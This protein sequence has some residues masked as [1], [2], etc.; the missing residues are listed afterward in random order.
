VI[1]S[2]LSRRPPNLVPIS[3]SMLA[4][5][6]AHYSMR[7][8]S[9]CIRPMMHVSCYDAQVAMVSSTGDTRTAMLGLV[10]A[11]TIQIAQAVQTASRGAADALV[12]QTVAEVEAM[13]SCQSVF[14]SSSGSSCVD[15][16]SD[17]NV[18]SSVASEALSTAESKLSASILTG[19]DLFLSAS[20][21]ALSI[22]NTL[23]ARIQQLNA[24]ACSATAST[25]GGF[26]T[27]AAS[28]GSANTTAAPSAATEP[29]FDAAAA[30]NSSS[31]DPAALAS[32]SPPTPSS[33]P[34]SGGAVPAVAADSRSSFRSRLQARLV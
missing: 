19:D 1:K 27:S 6:L 8:R 23:H 10:A 4:V 25:A 32:A 7:T 12:N 13:L 18:R 11:A 22:T 2:V 16:C 28:M 31:V 30:A 9:Q 14:A 21:Y 17:S 15:A 33:A 34:A 26:D 29:A 24:C 3:A 20:A 5:G